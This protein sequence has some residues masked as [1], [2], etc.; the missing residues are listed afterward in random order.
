MKYLFLLF[1]FSISMNTFASG[2]RVGNGGDICEY[3]M[4]NITK[5][6]EEWLI[7]DEYKGLQL[8]SGLIEEVYK[9]GMLNAIDKSF[10]SCS[11]EKLY[12]GN[13]EKTC[14]N[15]SDEVGI[16]RIQCNFERFMKTKDKEQY[17]LIHHELAGVAG[18]EKNNGEASTYTITNQ[19]S[20]FLEKELVYK[21]GIKKVTTEK[22][23]N[24]R[25]TIL[26]QEYVSRLI[27]WKP[28]SQLYAHLY[29][30]D[31]ISFC[32]YKGFDDVRDFETTIVTQEDLFYL[33]LNKYK[34]DDPRFNPKDL[35]IAELRMM[36]DGNF[37]VIYKQVKLENQKAFTK[38]TCFNH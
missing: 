21:L 9:E 10:L 16:L 12:I 33:K 19:I 35:S 22:S 37:V 24:L 23:F 7:K 32:R 11:S 29:Q 14:K 5:D 34:F 13:A 20:T 25:D 1:L 27:P 30:G 4:R 2:D 38:I 28:K 3:K 17:L 36:I 6:F 31:A 8:P 18:F 15:F 26:V